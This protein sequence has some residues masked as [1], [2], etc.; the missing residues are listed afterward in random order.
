MLLG[1]AHVHKLTASL[2]ASLGSPVPNAGRAGCDGAEGLVVFHP[3]EQMR[4]GQFVVG[5]CVAGVQEFARSDVEGCAPMPAFLVLFCPFITLAFQCVDMHRNGVVDVLHLLKG[6]DEGFYVV[7]FIHID[8]VQPH[9]AE[10]V[11]GARAV[12]L[13]QR[14]EVFIEST[15]IFGNGHLVVVDHDDE[16]CAQFGSPVETFE[17]LAAAE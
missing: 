17:C 5:F 11:V 4:S 13:S 8:V 14:V 9:G 3:C 16:V 7:T 1:N 6:F 12:R 10:E 15:M 2:L